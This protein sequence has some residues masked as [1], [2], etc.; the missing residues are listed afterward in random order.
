LII[1]SVKAKQI[2]GKNRQRNKEDEVTN[3]VLASIQFQHRF[4]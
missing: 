2:A 4:F 3:I 1:Q